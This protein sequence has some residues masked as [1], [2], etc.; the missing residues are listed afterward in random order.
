MGTRGFTYTT[1]TEE[2]MKKTLPF[3]MMILTIPLGLALQLDYHPLDCS[4]NQD[5][6]FL[7]WG[8]SFDTQHDQSYCEYH[9]ANGSV[10]DGFHAM[11]IHQE[12][13][14][15]T[16]Y[17]YYSYTNIDLWKVV[18]YTQAQGNIRD[19]EVSFNYYVPSYNGRCIQEERSVFDSNQW[20]SPLYVLLT[21][22][23][24]NFYLDDNFNAA[25]YQFNHEVVC[26]QEAYFTH[27]IKEFVNEYG[28]SFSGS[29]KQI[30]QID[31]EV[32]GMYVWN[33]TVKGNGGEIRVW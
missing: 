16:T 7:G 26:D 22:A 8:E 5:P 30:Y 1:K 33:V 21:N 23:E 18:G 24:T 12:P 20:A 3:L 10:N 29:S 31:L 17:D 28:S 19:V 4:Y 15:D 27:K 13:R 32:S 9:G 2:H 6:A 11:Y 14:Y 25:L